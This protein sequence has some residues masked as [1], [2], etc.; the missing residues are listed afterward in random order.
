MR[1]VSNSGLVTFCQRQLPDLW[2][3]G[4]QTLLVCPRLR[5]DL[6]RFLEAPSSVAW[7]VLPPEGGPGQGLGEGSRL[8]EAA[9]SGHIGVSVG[10]PSCPNSFWQVIISLSWIFLAISFELSVPQTH[11]L[12]PKTDQEI[13]GLN[14]STALYSKSK[15]VRVALQ[16]VRHGQPHCL[17]LAL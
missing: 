15:F 17:P 16:S 10:Q 11:H 13:N 8:D 9:G 4:D 1:R 2:L 12:F 3:P 7:R 14:P 6:A 5:R